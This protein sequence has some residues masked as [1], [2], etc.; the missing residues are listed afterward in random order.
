MSSKSSSAALTAA[1]A[2]AAFTVLSPEAFLQTSGLATQATSASSLRGSP[3]SQHVSAS[4][5]TSS[6]TS[7]AL[8]LG[9]AAGAVSVVASQIRSKG[10]AKKSATHLRAFENELGVQAPLGYWDP[11][12]ISKDGDVDAFARRRTTELKNGRVAMFATLG[13]IVPE[14]FRWPGLCAPSENLAFSDV[15]NGLAAIGKIPGEGWFQILIFAGAVEKGLYPSETMTAPGAYPNAG[16]LGIPNGSSLPEGA[17]R[18]TKLNAEL[19]NGRLAMM[20]I[21][22]MWFQDGLTGSAWGD[23]ANYTDSPLRAFEGE[24]GVQAPLGYWDPLGLSS[25]GDLATFQ[26]RRETE[27]KH[28]RVSMWAAMGYIAPE[29]F[30]WP[31]LLAPSSK[32]EFTD[33]PNGLAACSK[34][35]S[36]GWAQVILFCGCVETYWGYDKYTK[37]GSPGEYGWK[38]IT[39]TDPE[40]RK[41]KLN[42]ELANGRLAM[43]AVTGMFFQDGLT[44]SAWGDWANYVDS[45]LRAPVEA[46]MTAFENE[47]GVQEPVGFWD[48]A[49][50]T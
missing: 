12:G 10:K 27:I 31:G 47:L 1:A 20:A 29:Y 35:P 24:L 15:P 48:P 13:Y 43:M 41:R 9:A 8:G 28:G 6:A 32:L 22:G 3:A 19:A 34:V 37:G 36:N 4:S 21:T 11:L 45:P 30:R 5:A 17:A 18:N 50:F 23:W 42:A 25:D 44:G 16:V 33:V 2:A 40:T 14:Y 26:R 46:A 39:S 7:S 38:A 49:G